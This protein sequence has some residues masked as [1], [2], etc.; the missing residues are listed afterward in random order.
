[1]NIPYINSDREA[2]KCG[3]SAQRDREA[4]EHE[5]SGQSAAAGSS[6]YDRIR[7]AA[8]RGAY[9][10]VN[11]RKKSVRIGKTCLLEKGISPENL[12]LIS[13]IIPDG[14][15]L[16][17]LEELYHAYK[18]SVPDYYDMGIKRHSYFK[19]LELD[20]LPDDCHF[21]PVSRNEAQAELEGYI[22]CAMILSD[23][24]WRR[25]M[26]KKWYWASPKDTDLILLS[27]WFEHEE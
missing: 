12:P 14:R 25:Y 13:E 16:E 8:S 26:G 6:V 27:E 22:L 7:A 10:R 4:E 5:N 17:R 24:S 2:E 23:W 19:A 15:K 20:E 18:Y 1:M 9:V 3:S 11:F 21:H